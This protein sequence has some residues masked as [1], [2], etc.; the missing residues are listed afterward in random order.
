MLAHC[1]GFCKRCVFEKVDRT[2]E[3]YFVRRP[4][5]LSTINARCFFLQNYH[6]NS[7]FT[8]NIYYRFWLYKSDVKFIS[9][10][11]SKKW[12]K[13]MIKKYLIFTTWT[14]KRKQQS[15]CFNKD[16]PFINPAK[17]QENF[18]FTKSLNKNKWLKICHFYLDQ[19]GRGGGDL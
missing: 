1:S 11:N 13:R 3:S 7:N 18:L 8:N 19:R 9:V 6:E 4:P 5:N 14:K 2:R 17:R 16:T 12:M 10:F 15:G